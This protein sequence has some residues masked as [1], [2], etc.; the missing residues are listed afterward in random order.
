MEL[1]KQLKIESR[2]NPRSSIARRNKIGPKNNDK[3]VLD[4]LLIKFQAN[5]REINDLKKSNHEYTN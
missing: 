4:G 1:I 5:F 3:N 2:K